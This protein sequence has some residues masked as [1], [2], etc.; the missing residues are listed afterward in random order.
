VVANDG[1]DLD[2]HRGEVFGLLGPNGA[3]KTTLIKQMV[4]LLR[5]TAGDIHLFDRDVVREPDVIP[6]YVAYLSQTL[7][8]LYAYR[9]REA[10]Y[11]TGI[12]R[13]LPAHEAGAQT[14]DLLERLHFAHLSKRLVRNLSG[15]QKQLVA[16]ASALIAYRPVIVLDEPTNNLDPVARRLVWDVLDEIKKH[17]GVTVIFV[18]HNVLEAEQVLT[19]VA[20]IDEG[21]VIALGTPN[22]LKALVASQVRL[23]FHLKG[24]DPRL[25]LAGFDAEL[26]P[27]GCWR[28]MTQ[29]HQIRGTIERLIQEIGLENMDDLRVLP[30]S[31]E[32]VYLALD[33]SQRRI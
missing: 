11:Y 26:L 12:L 3:G 30:P 19:R 1:L 21:R 10:I 25:R 7:M 13:G 18:T 16:V 15:G 33:G 6:H 8:S 20:I 28:V 22:E 23:E 31:L 27:D 29:Q 14:D 2:I 4:G 9:V 32:D 24:G 5:P 17:W